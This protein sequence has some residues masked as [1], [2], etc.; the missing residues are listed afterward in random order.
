MK[1]TFGHTAGRKL[2]LWAVLALAAIGT[3]VV[4]TVATACE[5]HRFRAPYWDLTWIEKDEC[6]HVWSGPGYY[7]IDGQAYD[8]TLVV[9]F[10]IMGKKLVAHGTI[11]TTST[12]NQIYSTGEMTRSDTHANDWVGTY[13]ITGGT[14]RFANATGTGTDGYGI[15][16]DGTICF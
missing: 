4:A 9:R 7:I 11:T 10:H 13:V 1:T 8:A 2:M 15:G 5:V 16:S 14:G 12:G 6:Y 3:A